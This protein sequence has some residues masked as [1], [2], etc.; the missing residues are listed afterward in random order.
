MQKDFRNVSLQA[1]QNSF[2]KF[3]RHFAASLEC[4]TWAKGTCQVAFLGDFDVGVFHGSAH[5]P[6]FD[7]KQENGENGGNRIGNGTGK[8]YAAK[9]QE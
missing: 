2:K 4:R 3:Q 5:L 8:E 6:Q 9:A 1:M 7:S